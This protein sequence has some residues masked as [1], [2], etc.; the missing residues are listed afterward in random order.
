MNNVFRTI[1]HSKL[2][3]TIIISLYKLDFWR[4]CRIN[5]YL[6]HST[7]P[8]LHLGFGS[9]YLACWLNT[10]ITLK[11]CKEG[12]YLDVGRPFPLS[13]NSVNY[14]FSEHLFEHLTYPQALNMLSE[15]Y[16][17]L[18]PGGVMRLATPD[19]RFLLGLY[20]DP[21]KPIHKEYIEYS[22]K[23]GNIP[24]TPVF[25]INRFH[26]AWGHQIIYDKET[27]IGLLTQAGFTNI[28]QCEVSQ[29]E[30]SQLQNVEGHFHYLPYEYNRLETMIFEATK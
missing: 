14:I 29:S 21:E 3:S 15:S 30:H 27:L 11:A 17:V 22:A 8:K 26:T 25:V 4:K 13:D 28:C 20:Q 6:S 18:K 12:V 16:R 1:L 9:N 7:Q 5:K 24:A 2:V 10:D 19:L 23:E